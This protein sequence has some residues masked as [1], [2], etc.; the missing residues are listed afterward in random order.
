MLPG[1]L[2]AKRPDGSIDHANTTVVD[3]SVIN[4]DELLVKRR[5]VAVI[6]SI[7]DVQ[8]VWPDLS[9]DQTWEVLQRCW[10]RHDCEV[11]LTWTLIELVADDL[12]PEPV[13]D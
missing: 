1:T 7:E 4:V 10:R 12:F 9:D 6:W 2:L 3:A 5:Q 8:E 11:G 13:D